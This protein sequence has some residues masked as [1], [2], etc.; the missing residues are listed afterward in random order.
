M[1]LK[2]AIYPQRRLHPRVGAVGFLRG[3]LRSPQGLIHAGAGS[4]HG[5]EQERDDA[6]FPAVPV[7]TSRLR[8]GGGAGG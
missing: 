6:V 2:H 3:A 5:I 7:I 1:G 8:G 4:L